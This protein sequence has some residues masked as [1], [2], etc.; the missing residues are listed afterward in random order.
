MQNPKQYQ[1]PKLV[2]YGRIG[3]LT[4]GSG[5]S[6]PDFGGSFQTGFQL[7]NNN[8]FVIGATGCLLASGTS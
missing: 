5:G 4:L 3:Q 2:E 6:F 8:C 1:K 7:I